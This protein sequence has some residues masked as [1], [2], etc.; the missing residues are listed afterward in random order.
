MQAVKHALPLI[1]VALLAPAQQRRQETETRYSI[2][3]HYTKYESMVPMR[4]G[5]RL[6]TSIYVPK[7]TSQSYPILF[8]RTPY[9]VAPYGIDNYRDSLGPSDKFAQEGFIFAYQDVRGR[10]MS[11]ASS[12]AFGSF[13]L[14]ESGTKGRTFTNVPSDM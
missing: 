3:A 6:F 8:L 9:S 4:D 14:M 2:K 12:T 10:Y 11:E 7:D 1:L 5:V 13:A